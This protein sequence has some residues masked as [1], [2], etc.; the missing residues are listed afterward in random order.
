MWVMCMKG[1]P[2]PIPHTST[3]KS[4]KNVPCCKN[5]CIQT[6]TNVYNGSV[7]NTEGAVFMKKVK[8]LKGYVIAESKDG[9]FHI[10][11][12]DEWSYGEGFRYAEW[13]CDSLNESIEWVRSC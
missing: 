12:K 1:P 7:D 3:K 2:R 10:F 13:E 11:T 5:K 9:R 6:Y 8:T 4:N